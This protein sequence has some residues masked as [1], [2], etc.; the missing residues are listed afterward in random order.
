MVRLFSEEQPANIEALMLERPSG[1]VTLAREEQ[2]LNALPSS[3][4]T[5]DGIVTSVKDEPANALMPMLF[6]LDGIVTPDRPQSLNASSPMA[7]TLLGI[8]T[9]LSFSHL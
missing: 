5:L 2:P 9:C 6:T 3:V 1:S 8:V 7:V 4:V